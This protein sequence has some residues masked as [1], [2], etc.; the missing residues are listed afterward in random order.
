MNINYFLFSL[1]CLFVGLVSCNNDA[2]SEDNSGSFTPQD[3]SYITEYN[4]NTT[5]S[6]FLSLIPSGIKPLKNTEDHVEF[7]FERNNIIHTIHALNYGEEFFY[8]VSIRI[9]FN[10]NENLAEDVFNH[11]NAA[12]E[13]RFG[14]PVSAID[15]QDGKTLIYK[16]KTTDNTL[17]NMVNVSFNGMTLLLDFSSVQDVDTEFDENEEGD[18]VQRGTDGTWIWVPK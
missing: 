9:N 13:K 5:K 16:D 6:Q 17:I 12:L 14:R 3:F 11:V 8:M 18:W 4:F 15:L 7:E 2:Q 1:A 10:G